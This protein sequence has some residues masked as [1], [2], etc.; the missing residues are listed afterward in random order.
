MSVGRQGN[1]QGQQRVDIPHL[2]AIEAAVAGDFDLLAGVMLAG[3]AP[4]ITSGFYVLTTGVS[5]ATN[6][7]IRV[8]GGSLIHF[9][10]SESGSI[11]HVPENRTDEQLN[12]TN[13]R[14]LGS[15][16]PSAVNYVGLDF[17][18]QADDSTVD[19]VEFIDTQSLTETPVSIPLARTTDYR[20]VISTLD[21]DN[22]PGVAPICKVTLDFDGTITT[23]EDAR[24]QMF[25]LGQG[26]T[27]PNAFS[28]FLWPDGRKESANSDAF[29]GGD[30][31]IND[32][33]NW[34]DAIMSRLWEVGGG[35][36]WYSPTNY[37]NERLART[38][39]P[40]VSNG[41]YFE[42]DGSNLHWQGLVW[43]FANSTGVTN[44]VTDVTSDTPGL[45]DLVD[46]D[47]IYV[48]VDRTQSTTVVAAKGALTDLGSPEIPG[49]RYVIAWCHDGEIYTRDQSYAVNSAF[50]LATVGAAGMVKLSATNSTTSYPAQVATVDD[51]DYFAYAGGLT[52]GGDFFGGAGDIQVGGWYAADHNVII[53]TTE[54]QYETLIQGE[55]NWTL[56]ATSALR[57]HQNKAFTES[58]F[59]RILT[60][61]GYDGNDLQEEDCF[62]FQAAGHM[63]WKIVENTPAAPPATS[64]SPLVAHT[65][66]R[67]NGE[68]SPDTR[69]QFCIMWRDGT[70][71]VIAESAAY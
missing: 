55:N 40:F 54:T 43:I 35:E 13:P 37:G 16:T 8:A 41:E 69:D 68:S 66:F 10:A 71:D 26:G 59:Y 45:T 6:L 63:S 60:L 62:A 53:K 32:L 34:M 46:G 15:F 3:K 58:S 57:V 17:I 20:I 22:N 44:E 33:K 52:R 19:L 38:G 7:K 25:R 12:S 39:A 11:F 31:A 61:S 9:L 29:T 42:W 28:S 36:Y 14:V 30:K 2:R 18:R 4:L 51:I 70:V 64:T 48:D 56:N 67:T 50:S 27:L 21:F 49:S 5:I 65:Y 47:C 1:W 23:I 24:P